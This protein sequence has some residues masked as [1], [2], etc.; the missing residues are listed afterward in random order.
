MI[1]S[2]DKKHSD[3]ELLARAHHALCDAINHSD[4]LTYDDDSVDKWGDLTRLISSK[5]AAI[6]PKTAREW[7]FKFSVEMELFDY[8][9]MIEALARDCEK[10]T[11]RAYV[12]PIIGKL[13]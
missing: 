1:H 7:A 11:G 8:C 10:I 9:P 2:I 5:I 4:K 13:K 12:P 3:I 6:E